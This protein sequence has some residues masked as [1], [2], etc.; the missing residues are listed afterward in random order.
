MQQIIV[1]S[2]V[3]QQELFEPVFACVAHSPNAPGQVALVIASVPIG[4]QKIAIMIQCD[5]ARSKMRIVA[6]DEA[7]FRHNLPALI[8]VI[9][10]DGPVGPVEAVGPPVVE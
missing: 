9:P 5:M 2:E 6:T 1:A 10:E 4:D 7:L 3:G 8:G